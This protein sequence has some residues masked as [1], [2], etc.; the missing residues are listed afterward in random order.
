MYILDAHFWRPFLM[1]I[2][3][4]HFY[5]SFLASIRLH[6]WGLATNDHF[7]VSFVFSRHGL[8]DGAHDAHDAKK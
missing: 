1:H 4:V 5:C 7:N 2:F 8:G 3:D 6:F